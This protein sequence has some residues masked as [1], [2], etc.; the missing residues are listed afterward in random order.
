MV[1]VNVDLT[2]R[3]ARLVGHVDLA[4]GCW[5]DLESPWRRVWWFWLLWKRGYGRFEMGKILVWVLGNVL[6]V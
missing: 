2:C 3:L 5:A 1:N 6:D 4:E